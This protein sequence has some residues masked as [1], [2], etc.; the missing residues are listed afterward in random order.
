MAILNYG[1]MVQQGLGNLG[2]QLMQAQGQREARQDRQAN[3]D[4][5]KGLADLYS[6][7]ATTQELYE[8]GLQNPAVFQHVGQ[9]IG[10]KSD[11]TKQLMQDTLI[12]A[13][14]NPEQRDQIIAQGSEAIK[15]AGGNPQYLSQA[16]GDDTEGFERG[17]VPFLA[18]LGGQGADFAKTYMGMKP[19][20]AEAP[21]YQSIQ[22]DSDGNPF[23]LN[24]ATGKFEPVG[25]GF[26]KGKAEPSTVVN[27]GKG[28]TEQAKT[29]AKAEGENYNSYVKDAAS[30]RQNDNTLNRLDKLNEVAFSGVAAPAYKVAARLGDAIGIETEGLTETE[31]FD[32]LSNQLVLGQTSKLTGVLTDKDMDLLASTVPQL[33]Q[34]KE[35]RKQLISIMKE[36]NSA[37]KDK[38]RLAAKF[39]KENK[40]QFDDMAFQEWLSEQPKEDRIAKIIGEK[41][42]SAAINWS[43]M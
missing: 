37:T 19:K 11:Q 31:L 40:G 17:A 9:T 29:I 41:P 36:I 14:Q 23:G 39:R 38:A 18:S 13:L 7:N 43:D 42:A 27:V 1:G 30:A 21:S 3:Q 4:A 6:N 12:S 5:M 34:T 32:S 26:V 15:A 22:Y 10:F 35:G 28:E 8:Y 33:S 24:K 25:G 2:N 16:I 20:A